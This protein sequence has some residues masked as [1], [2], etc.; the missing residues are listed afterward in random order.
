MKK[1]QFDKT[2]NTHMAFLPINTLFS[3]YNS[4]VVYRLTNPFPDNKPNH[5]E[6][7]RVDTGKTK[8]M[9]NEFDSYDLYKQTEE[10]TKPKTPQA[11]RFA[12]FTANFTPNFIREAFAHD[13]LLASHLQLKFN[14]MNQNKGFISCGDFMQWFL[15]L[16]MDNQL[17]LI[18]WI[19]NNYKGM[20]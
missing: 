11:L 13:Q 2:V 17:H 10:P 16:S 15:N 6:V 20:D 5:V 9:P 7:T 1:L 19:D 8:F 3:K 4:H 12:Y 18:N 14:A